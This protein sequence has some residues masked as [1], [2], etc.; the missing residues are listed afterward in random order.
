MELTAPGHLE[1][2]GAFRLLDAQGDIRVQ[3]AEQPVAQMAAGHI[4]SLLAC[5][6]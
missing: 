2:V 6:R 3:L 4:F 5:K 1:G